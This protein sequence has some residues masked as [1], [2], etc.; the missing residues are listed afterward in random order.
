MYTGLLRGLKKIICKHEQRYFPK[1][2]RSVFAFMRENTTKGYLRRRLFFA[3]VGYP[4]KIL[5]TYFSRVATYIGNF[6]K[7]VPYFP[8]FTRYCNIAQVS[9]REPIVSKTLVVLR[10]H[11]AG[12]SYDRYLPCVST[13]IFELK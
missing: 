1:D 7:T 3:D 8:S 9:Q 6:Q 13:N 4:R 10:S 11:L 5:A 2:Y 12:I